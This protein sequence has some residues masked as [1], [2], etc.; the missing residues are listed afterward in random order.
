[1]RV[2]W[3]WIMTTLNFSRRHNWFKSNLNK[4]RSTLLLIPIQFNF[5]TH[6]LPTKLWNHSKYRVKD[7]KGIYFEIFTSCTRISLILV[8]KLLLSGYT[9]LCFNDACWRRIWHCEPSLQVLFHYLFV[10]FTEYV[11]IQSLFQKNAIIRQIYNYC[12]GICDHL[13][14]WTEKLLWLILNHC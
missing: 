2:Y 12:H 6:T 10:Q 5:D 1:M 3:N 8:W 7:K 4:Y 14:W 9:E 13:I 11:R